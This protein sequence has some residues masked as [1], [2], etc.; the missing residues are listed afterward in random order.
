[1]RRMTDGETGEGGDWILFQIQKFG[2][3]PEFERVAVGN[4]SETCRTQP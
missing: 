4:A 2:Q 3:M 1:M